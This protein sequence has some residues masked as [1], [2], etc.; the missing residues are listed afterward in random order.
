MI[1]PKLYWILLKKKFCRSSL[2]DL[3]SSCLKSQGFCSFQ[4]IF[5]NMFTSSFRLFILLLLGLLLLWME[6]KTTITSIEIKRLLSNKIRPNSGGIIEQKPHNFISFQLFSAFLLHAV[7]APLETLVLRSTGILSWESNAI[8]YNTDQ[9]RRQVLEKGDQGWLGI[10]SFKYSPALGN[11]S[12][13][14]VPELS[15]D[16]LYHWIYYSSLPAFISRVL[17]SIKPKI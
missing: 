4:H 9:V 2:Y 8:W 1:S 6:G 17:R 12:Y 16:N 3:F 14:C 13:A 10:M 11:T 15:V 7:I 5:M